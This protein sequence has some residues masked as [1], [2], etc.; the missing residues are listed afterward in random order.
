MIYYDPA[1]D[2]PPDA[3]ALRAELALVRE[4]IAEALTDDK[5]RELRAREARLASLLGEP[6]TS[7]FTVADLTRALDERDEARA[8]VDRLRAVIDDPG[9]MV[10]TWRPTRDQIVGIAHAQEVVITVPAGEIR[11]HL[12]ARLEALYE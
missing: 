9:P 5:L 1:A 8:E 11:D 3:A 4:C 12:R 2:A 6:M 7:L 10:S